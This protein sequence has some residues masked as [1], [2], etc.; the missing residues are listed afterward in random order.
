MTVNSQDDFKKKIGVIENIYR[1]TLVKLEKLNK[2]KIDLITQYSRQ[3]AEQ[4]ISKIL[5][6]IKNK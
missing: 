2:K 3:A 4:Q 6:D 5:K 1:Q